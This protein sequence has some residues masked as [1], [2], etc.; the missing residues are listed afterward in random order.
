MASTIAWLERCGQGDFSKK[1]GQSSASIGGEGVFRKESPPTKR[2]LLLQRFFSKVASLPS[3]KDVEDHKVFASSCEGAKAGMK[4]SITAMD[5]RT[6][7]HIK[8]HHGLFFGGN[9][10]RLPWQRSRDGVQ[11]MNRTTIGGNMRKKKIFQG[12]QG[13]FY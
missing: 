7:V 8:W 11:L 10:S 4:H 2:C 13:G 9:L 1:H 6:D 12:S 3:F 5:H